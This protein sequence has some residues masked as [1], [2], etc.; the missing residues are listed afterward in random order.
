MQAVG[1]VGGSL[2][3]QLTQQSAKLMK[4]RGL[5]LKVVGIASGHHAMF[6]RRGI[7]LEHC[8]EHLAES[9]PSNL[10]RLRDE[11][12]GMNIFNSVFV[13]C[14][15]SAEVAGLY[16]EFLE[17][18]ISVVAA[19][20]VAA[21]SDYQTYK[22]LKSTARQRGVKFLFETNVG[23]G[24]PIIRTMNDLLNSG[25]KILKIEAV[26]SGTLN[27][28]FNKISADVPFSKTVQLAKQEGYSEPD[29]RI[30]LS[31]KD[32]IRKLVILTREAGYQI[33]QEDVE[34]HLFVPDSYFDGTLDDF[35]RDLPKLD[36]DFEKRRQ[37]L[38]Q[39]GKRWL[40]CGQI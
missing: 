30:D 11:V 2:I 14:T 36:E 1:T 39:E 21:S 12:I 6:D 10:Q 20:K 19:N 34:K 31:G 7:D 40:F 15:A 5:K 26:L 16:Q 28:I 9:A 33:E 4:E 35:W 22:T 3:D 38:E 8:R 29:P 17:H 27:F 23:A 25:D 24:L 37:K 32:V 18:N 13:D